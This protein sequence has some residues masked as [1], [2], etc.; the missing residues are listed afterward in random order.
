MTAV[1]YTA[2]RSLIAGHSINVSYSLDLRVVSMPIDR[3]PNVTTQTTLDGNQEAI[4]F[5]GC[6][7]YN[8]SLAVHTASQ[9]LQLK[10]FL[11]SV[12]AKESFTFDPYGS[13]NVPAGPLTATMDSAGYQFTREPLGQGGA[14]DSYRATF[15]VRVL[16][17]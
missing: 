11:D 14:N 10:E 8:V 13:A 12:E 1:T 6:E 4:R 17:P 3:E 16:V 15:R 7:Y 9:I 2:R 5:Y